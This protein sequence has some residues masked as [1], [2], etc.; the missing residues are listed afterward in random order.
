MANINDIL[1][2]NHNDE[3]TDE[4]LLNYLSGKLTGEDLQH[5]EE[6]IKDDAFM[7][8]AVDGLQQFSSDAKLDQYVKNLNKNLQQ[9]L[10]TKK[11]RKWKRRLENPSWITMAT[12]I[13]LVLCVLAYAVIMFIRNH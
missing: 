12:I 5:L 11:Q 7:K 6:H 2:T 8:D 9:Q 10:A 4:Q 3:F 13:I 1:S